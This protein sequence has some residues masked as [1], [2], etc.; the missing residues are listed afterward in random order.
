MCEFKAGGVVIEYGAGVGGI[1]PTESADGST[2]NAYFELVSEDESARI[3]GFCN[4]A[5]T[6]DVT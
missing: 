5:L 2:F 1:R 3:S 6:G 4:L